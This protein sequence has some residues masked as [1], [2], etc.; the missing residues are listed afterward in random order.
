[1]NF[2]AVLND[3]A[4]GAEEVWP[5]NGEIRIC[6]ELSTEA[7]YMT[8][9]FIRVIFY[10]SIAD[11]QFTDYMHTKLFDSVEESKVGLDEWDLWC[12][13]PRASEDR[14][15]HLDNKASRYGFTI[16]QSYFDAT[17]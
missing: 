5:A 12:S 9:R 1:M 14:L 2:T 16:E 15:S 8:D 7:E 4:P 3:Y 13:T 10:G 11:G 6:F 17:N